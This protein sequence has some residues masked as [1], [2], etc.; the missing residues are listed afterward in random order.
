MTIIIII[1]Y[2]EG[3]NNNNNSNISSGIKH[4]L[5]KQDLM[6]RCENCWNT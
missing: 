5:E 1:Y 4:R 3:K 6:R 2:C